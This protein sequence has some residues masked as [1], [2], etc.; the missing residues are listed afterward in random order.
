MTQA[1]ATAAPVTVDYTSS[2][3]F[4]SLTA[5]S[6]SAVKVGVCVTAQG[7]TDDTGALTA[8]AI[9][10]SAPTNGTCQSGFGGRGFGGGRGTGGG[11]P[12]TAGAGNA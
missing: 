1:G 12:S 5:A 4:T 8:R 3:L 7:R 6:A 11:A 9:A 10:V 2:T